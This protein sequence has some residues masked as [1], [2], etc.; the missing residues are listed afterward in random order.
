MSSGWDQFTD[1]LATDLAP[2]ITLFG[3]RLTKQFLSEST[4][5]LDNLIFAFSPLG[6]LT[7]VVSV[8]R[9][10]GNSTLRAFIG[11]AQEG[12][13]EAEHE[14]LSC[15]SETTAEL[16]NNGGI[17]RVFGRPQILEVVVWNEIDPTTKETVRKIGTLHQAILENAWI[18]GEGRS[19]LD[20][21]G[22]MPELDI[23]NLSL[24][25]GI[26]RRSQ[27]WF[28]CAAA[29]GIGLQIGTLAYAAVTVFIYPKQFLKDG[30]PVQSYAF[31]LFVFGSVLLCMGMFLCAYIIERSSTE[32]YL[33]PATPSTMYWLQPG[34]Q[35]VGD[36]V[37]GAFLGVD[38]GYEAPPTDDLAY[39]KSVRG[40]GRNERGPLLLFTIL[41]TL[42]GFVVQ[43]V[44]IRGL[45][46]S[47][48]IAVMGSTLL[49][50]IVRTCLRAKRIG[51]E[52]NRMTEAER[53]LTAHKNQE[54][55]CFAFH[56]ENVHTFSIISSSTRRPQSSTQPSDDVST[57]SATPPTS[58]GTRL[59]RTRTRLAQLTSIQSHHPS[60]NWDGLPIRQAAQSL[61]N[62]IEKTMNLVS[63]WKATTDDTAE[64]DIAFVC[65]E[66]HLYPNADVET[67][68]ITL[69]RPDGTLH[70]RVD[71]NELE[72][73]LGLWAWYLIKINPDWVHHNFGRLVGLNLAQATAEET[74]LDYYRWIYRHTEPKMVSKSMVNL[75]DQMFG[76]WSEEYLDDR[77]ILAVKTG[78]CLEIMVAQDIYVQFLRSTL[79]NL[80]HL[81]GD[82]DLQ[83]GPQSGF[84]V[85]NSR[86]DE[87]VNC[88]E[89]ANL[90]TREDALL[91]IVPVLQ[92][93]CMLPELAGDSKNI[94]TR[95][96]QAIAN[97]N[98]PNA[99][100]I[101]HWLCE[102]SHG[103][104]FEHSLF[105]LG[106]LCRRAMVHPDT[107]IQNE[108]Y[109]QV[110]IAV[111]DDPRARFFKTSKI[112][113]SA[114][115][116][117]TDRRPE[118]WS[119][120]VS[121]L[122]WIAWNM[123]ENHCDKRA[124]QERL[125]NF[126][127]N[128]RSVPESE[129]NSSLAEGQAAE[130]AV[131]QWLTTSDEKF[132]NRQGP[133][134]EDRSALDW[135]CQNG[136][137]ALMHW[138]IT[139]W[140]EYD[141]KRPGLVYNALLWAAEGRYREAIAALCR[142]GVDINMHEPD[143]ESGLTPLM[144]TIA[145]TDRSAAL[146]LLEVGADVNG[147][148]KRGATP[149][150]TASN[151]GDEETVLRLLSLSAQIN[152]QDNNGFSPLFWST[153]S[154]Q[155][156]VAKILLDHGARVDLGGFGVSTPLI[157]AAAEDLVEM[158]KLL[159]S[160]GA[161]VNVQT[162]EG[163]TALILATR[164]KNTEVVKLLLDY[165]ADVH[166]QTSSDETALDWAEGMCYLEGIELLK[167]AY[168]RSS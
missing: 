9:V 131:L 80:Q 120:F 158:V 154:N 155:V 61:A 8:I 84:F 149:L 70:W 100:S 102:R 2:L 21:R 98:W 57:E 137:H 86:L 35:D 4:S 51:P 49:M 111:E 127:I 41:I 14:L 135:V 24:N 45:H 48:I 19:M 124:I 43:F 91:C 15:V 130:Q 76:N 128:A 160:R 56:L 50:A 65:D 159:L 75:P 79:G 94:R 25:K 16:F 62:T 68:T 71:E 93:Q 17:S 18:V 166:K 47:V 89:S 23:P 33:H 27:G 83:H 157:N 60:M 90:G 148:D 161:D 46:S 162:Y 34:R 145:V 129:V 88:F 5:L 32:C 69:S 108:G 44:G 99:F 139:R 72:A 6:I 118:R 168:S 59:I 58:L 117:S 144:R 97:N 134:M 36:Q 146:V 138:L 132:L 54:L 40:R 77:E 10:C 125:E 109:N 82:V 133:G 119:E 1:N 11:R 13:G 31:P 52:E 3:E 164:N 106:Y 165:H 67:Y 152:A 30:D 105:E 95:V 66:Y 110:Y 104:E 163:S 38:E 113:R 126:G 107:D 37:F 73:I 78:N 136:H 12:P 20:I 112:Q 55:D 7:A 53:Q 42:I 28:Y 151:T 87:L 156:A 64:F 29:L 74:D 39:V 142:R 103:A 115:W 22:Y 141:D 143:D 150:M 121:Q 140:V 123:A 122:G 167:Q 26:K 101:L 116:M 85:Y 153:I 92:D 96:G 63:S 81:G 114:E 147:R